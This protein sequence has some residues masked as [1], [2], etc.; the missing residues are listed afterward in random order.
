MRQGPGRTLE[1]RGEGKGAESACED[2]R[3]GGACSKSSLEV[4]VRDE[5]VDD[6]LVRLQLQELQNKAEELCGLPLPA[7]RAAHA[8]DLDRLLQK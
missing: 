6:L 7:V 4:L 8:S 3:Q 1:G 5:L 2:W